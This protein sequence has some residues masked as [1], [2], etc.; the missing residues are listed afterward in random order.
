M[1]DWEMLFNAIQAGGV[2]GLLAMAVYAG[3]RGWVYPAS[4]VERL[5]P[6]IVEETLRQLREE[7][8]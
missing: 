8:K 1:L 3:Y 5:I 7:Q 6:R 4:V 2:V